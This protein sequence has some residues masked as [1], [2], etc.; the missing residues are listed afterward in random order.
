MK[1]KIVEDHTP[2]PWEDDGVKQQLPYILYVRKWYLFFP[3]YIFIRRFHT[4]IKA[5]EYASDYSGWH[6]GKDEDFNY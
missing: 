5:H 2:P 6:S 3:Y 4:R 1:F